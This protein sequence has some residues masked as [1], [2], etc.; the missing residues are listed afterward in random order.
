MAREAE[1]LRLVNE[2]RSRGANCGTFAATGPLQMNPNLSCAARYHSKY[3]SDNNHFDHTSPGSSWGNE[4]DDRSR[5]AGFQ[6]FAASENIAAGTSSPREVI[7]LWL[8]SPGHCANLMDP[9]V[10]LIGVG[11]FNTGNYWTQVFGTL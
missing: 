2:V 10:T 5:S 11:L 6:G 9:R 1:V 4:F 7:N 3:M 8:T